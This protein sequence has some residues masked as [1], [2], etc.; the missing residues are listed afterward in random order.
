MTKVA[1]ERFQINVITSDIT[2]M[3]ETYCVAGWNPAAGQ[4]KRL[5]ING[6]H[7]TDEDLGRMGKYASL[8]VSVIPSENIRDFPHRAEDIWISD[9]LKVIKNYENPRKLAEDLKESVSPTIQRVFRGKLQEKS[10]VPEG[11]KCSSL[12]AIIIPS[13]DITF[14]KE[15]GKLRVHFIDDD[16][17]DYNLRVTCKYLRDMLDD[18]DNLD[19]F[20]KEMK[21]S[22]SKAHV[23]VGLAKPYAYKN[24]NCY[25]MAN[26]VFFH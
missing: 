16:K 7:W 18:L 14:V 11:E 6:K 19:D 26:G 15:N 12:G 13:K 24:N 17:E 20:N 8:I 3:K 21:A 1:N 5:L 22:G 4:M 10:Y 25:L 23:R 9:D 2:Y